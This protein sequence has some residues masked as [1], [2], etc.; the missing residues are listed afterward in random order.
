MME[1]N[2]EMTLYHFFIRVYWYQLAP[3]NPMCLHY[4]R[5]LILLVLINTFISWLVIEDR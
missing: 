2:V 3:G 4:M 5:L 1:E